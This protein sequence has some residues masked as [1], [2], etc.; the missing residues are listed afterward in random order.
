VLYDF[1]VH[2]ILSSL[3]LLCYNLMIM[4]HICIGFVLVVRLMFAQRFITIFN[5]CYH[6]SNHLSRCHKHTS[7]SV[8]LSILRTRIIELNRKFEKSE[9]IY[10]AVWAHKYKPT[11]IY[12]AKI[13]I[14]IFVLASS[15]FIVCFFFVFFCLFFFLLF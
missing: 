12:E 2:N 7:L 15:I 3:L 11:G 5:C 10:K 14:N 1:I 8:E 13:R 6:T 9:E 4:N